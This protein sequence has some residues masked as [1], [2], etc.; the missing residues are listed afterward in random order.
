MRVVAD[1]AGWAALT[2]GQALSALVSDPTAAAN[3]LHE[4]IRYFRLDGVVVG[5]SGGSLQVWEECAR[6]L[7]ALLGRERVWGAVEGPAGRIQHGWDPWDAEDAA[8]D[9]VEQWAAAGAGGVV[10]LEAE[11]GD[12]LEARHQPVLRR[13]AHYGL[14]VLLAVERGVPRD[15]S[16]WWAVAVPEG[17]SPYWRLARRWEPYSGPGLLLR[18]PEEVTVEEAQRLARRG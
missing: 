14:R 2:R 7:S 8:G 18:W 15:P 17:E 5:W 3:A 10:I 13:A 16:P 12:D 4:G 9:E 11:A 6:R 1:I